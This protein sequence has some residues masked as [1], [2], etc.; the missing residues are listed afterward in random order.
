MGNGD[1]SIASEIHSAFLRAADESPRAIALG[2]SPRPF[3]RGS[4]R[5]FPTQICVMGNLHSCR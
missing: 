1:E 4:L 3:S 5:V 2:V